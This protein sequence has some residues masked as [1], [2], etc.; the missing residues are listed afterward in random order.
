MK[1]VQLY[2]TSWVGVTK[3]AEHYY[4]KLFVFDEDKIKKA[5]ADDDYCVPVGEPLRYVPTYEG[6]RAIAE[7]D[8]YKGD[9]QLQ[10]DI[11]FYLSNGT[12]RFFSLHQMCAEAHKKYPDLPIYGFFP[13]H[14]DFCKVYGEE[15][16][17][18]IYDEQ[19][20]VIL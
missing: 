2:C 11:D 14:K 19:D 4:C 6:A 5:V 1:A 15:T 13:R 9:R 20:Y 7:K 3:D 16:R 17:K 18:G 8:N 10:L 12:T